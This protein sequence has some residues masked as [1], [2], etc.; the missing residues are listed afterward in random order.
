MRLHEVKSAIQSATGKT[1]FPVNGGLELFVSADSANE[2]HFVENG[3][4]NLNVSFERKMVKKSFKGALF[5]VPVRNTGTA[6][7]A[8][9][10]F[11]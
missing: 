8:D 6:W 3:L 1:P 10:E 2:I 5:F 9:W 4:N 11:V 7:N